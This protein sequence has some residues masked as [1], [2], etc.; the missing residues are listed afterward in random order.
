MFLI[1]IIKRILSYS[2][3]VFDSITSIY[4]NFCVS[5]TGIHSQN[6]NN[7]KSFQ[8]DDV[9]QSIQSVYCFIKKTFYLS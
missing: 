2:F 5:L 1:K 8:Y 7:E 6:D 3:R 9:K 4:S